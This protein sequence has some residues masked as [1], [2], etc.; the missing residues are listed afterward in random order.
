MTMPKPD[1]D[2]K[3]EL[4]L[5]PFVVIESPHWGKTYPQRN[6]NW[7]YLTECCRHSVLSGEAPFASHGFYTQ[8]L[9]DDDP[10]SRALGIKLGQVVMARA[11]FV[12]VYCDL[13]ISPGMKAG[14]KA[15]HKLGLVVQKRK[16]GAPWKPWREENV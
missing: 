12:A 6:H 7:L 11:S 2:F 15:A 4:L 13:G 8:F 5:Q 9:N 10:F 1:P 3:R 14:I 16:L